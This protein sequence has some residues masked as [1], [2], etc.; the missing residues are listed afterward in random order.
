M[1]AMM[2]ELKWAKLTEVYGRMEAELIESYLEANGIDAELFQESVGHNIYPVTV[3]G[4][5]TV[6][7]FVEKE[8]LTEAGRLLENFNQ[9]EE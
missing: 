7:I 9:P 4:L 5:G 8:N 1:E 3:D 2:D 6:Q